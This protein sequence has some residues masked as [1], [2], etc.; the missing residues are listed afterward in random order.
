MPPHASKDCAL[1]RG[2]VHLAV[3][4]TEIDVLTT[5]EVVISAEVEEIGDLLALEEHYA[6]SGE[7]LPVAQV[8]DT[9][10][11]WLLR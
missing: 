1:V 5:D 10:L 2:L 4:V 7:H 9:S 11:T 8:L 6:L 3:P